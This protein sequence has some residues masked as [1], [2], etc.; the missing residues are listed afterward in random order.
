MGP[1]PVLRANLSEE[2][3]NTIVPWGRDELTGLRVK[4]SKS[5]TLNQ[6]GHQ[7]KS[8][9]KQIIQTNEQTNKLTNSEM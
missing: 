4:E 5:P 3:A 6:N 7:E 1:E 9:A 8:Q 2:G